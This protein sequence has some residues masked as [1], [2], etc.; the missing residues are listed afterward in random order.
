MRK[1][2][3]EFLSLWE[4]NS[5]IPEEKN[6]I[7]NFPL[8]Y[9]PLLQ[10]PINRQPWNLLKVRFCHKSKQTNIFLS[11]NWKFEFWWFLR[12]PQPVKGGLLALTSLSQSFQ[13]LRHPQFLSNFQSPKFKFSL[14]GKKNVRLFGVMT[15]TI[16]WQKRT[17][18]FSQFYVKN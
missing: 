7:N 5:E 9:T 18:T 4:L 11:W 2:F 12:L 6:Q 10:R 16:F 8:L 15:K 1:C 14:S 3:Q 13:T 17:F